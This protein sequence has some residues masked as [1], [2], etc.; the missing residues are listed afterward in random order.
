LQHPGPQRQQPAGEGRSARLSLP[1][2]TGESSLDLRVVVQK[3]HY[4]TFDERL[5]ERH[6]GLAP[7]NQGP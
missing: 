2:V 5:F 6:D 4:K 1:K 7:A 3:K